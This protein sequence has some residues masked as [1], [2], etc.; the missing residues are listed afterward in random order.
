MILIPA[1]DFDMGSTEQESYKGMNIA[2]E[3]FKGAKLSLF[4]AETPKHKV[5]LD[6]FYIDKTPITNEQ[7]NK[8]VEATGYRAQGKWKDYFKP[9]RLDH[10]VVNVTWD[11]AKAYADWAGKRLPTEA[12]WEKAAR[13]T[14]GREWPWGEDWDDKKA[15]S[16]V[17]N[18]EGTTSVRAYPQGASPYG[19]LDMAGN[20]WNWCNDWFEPQYYSKSPEKN[21]QGPAEGQARVARGG[22]WTNYPHYLR[23]TTRYRVFPDNYDHSKGFRCVISEKDFSPEKKK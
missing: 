3:F 6:A 4:E 14:D 12:E 8:F 15:N 9:D 5:Y 7:F 20:V 1:G 11:D 16:R 10:P 17:S 19:L 23:T 21:P 18:N 2:R 13:G 22:A